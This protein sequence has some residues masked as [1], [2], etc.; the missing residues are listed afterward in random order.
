MLQCLR[1]KTS[2][3]EYC[4]FPFRSFGSTSRDQEQSL[5]LRSTGV[6]GSNNGY[7]NIH[8]DHPDAIK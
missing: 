5:V 2:G 7:S 3:T 4:I 6:K 1:T 8:D